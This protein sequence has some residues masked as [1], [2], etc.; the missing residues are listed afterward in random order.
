MKEHSKEIVVFLE[1][2]PDAVQMYEKWI[3]QSKKEQEP[4]H[5]F[6]KK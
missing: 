5:Y 6:T 4:V 1:A 2:N 3:R